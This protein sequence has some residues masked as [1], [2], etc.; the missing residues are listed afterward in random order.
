MKLYS[1]TLNVS[2]RINAAELTDEDLETVFQKIGTLIDDAMD[3]LKKDIASAVGK[4]IG[5]IEIKTQE[6]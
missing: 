3:Q 6:W 2:S 1:T 4:Q 5:D